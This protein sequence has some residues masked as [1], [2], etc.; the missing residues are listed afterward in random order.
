MS[1]AVVQPRISAEECWTPDGARLDFAD[2]PTPSGERPLKRLTLAA[3]LAG[4]LAAGPAFAQEA[5][6]TAAIVRRAVFEEFHRKN[7]D[8]RVVNAGGLDSSGAQA[9]NMFLMSMAG[10]SAPD[11]FYVNFR[12]Y[13]TFLDQG[14][15]RPLD[16]QIGRAHV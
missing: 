5:T 4:I 15:C 12:Q 9:D 8:V 10:D 6:A 1:Y 16:D 7:P 2:D 13:Y 14:F 11:V 3:A